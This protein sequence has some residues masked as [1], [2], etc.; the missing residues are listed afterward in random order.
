MFE[1]Y[2]ASFKKDLY[3]YVRRRINNDEY[4]EDIT[5]DVFL[6]LFENSEIMRKRDDNGIKAWLYTVAR[7][8]I[9]D[10]FRK[11]RNNMEVA[12]VHEDLF[13][14]TPNNEESHVSKEIRD[15]KIALVKDL[16]TG[17]TEEEKE[18]LN[19]RLYEEFSF[20]EIAQ[21]LEKSEGAVKMKYYRL[22]ETVQ[23][24]L[25]YTEKQKLDSKSK[26]LKEEKE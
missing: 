11:K 26:N 2:Y 22:L 1:K 3:W 6:K 8:R 25:N 23:E 14:F 12:G 4:A 21:V 13:D 7:N 19:L 17:F 16:L 18:L 5:A 10:E 24:Q 20:N 9:I 15:E